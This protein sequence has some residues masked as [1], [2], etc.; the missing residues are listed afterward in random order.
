MEANT[1]IRIEQFDNGITLRCKDLGGEHDDIAVVIPDHSVN[2]E[3]GK[4]IMED[5]KFAMDR[6]LK[7]KVK[8][9]IKIETE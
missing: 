2:A 5:V 4:M 8:I 6:E 3:V 9:F 1:E 7:G